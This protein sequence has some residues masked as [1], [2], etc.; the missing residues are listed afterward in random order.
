ML[1]INSTRK[2]LE[3]RNQ[4]YTYISYETRQVYYR[5]DG[6]AIN[7]PYTKDSLS[8]IE[9]YARLLMLVIL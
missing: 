8:G 3:S 2:K 4:I 5:S 9:R 6:G 1:K 7:L